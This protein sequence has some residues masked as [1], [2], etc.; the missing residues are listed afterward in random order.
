MTDFV[1]YISV[2]L[3]VGHGGSKDSNK[4]A[5]ILTTTDRNDILIYLYV[6]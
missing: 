5:A 3:L 4:M 6:A 2:K 1:L